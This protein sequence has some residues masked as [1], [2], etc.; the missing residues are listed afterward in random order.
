[1]RRSGRHAGS[2][3][4]EP[5]LQYSARQAQHIARRA[6][7]A[8]EHFLHIEAASGIILLIAVAASLLWANSPFADVY[9]H[10]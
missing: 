4:P 8:L 10:L 5:M 6:L 1:M 3:T 9:H 2:L 7:T